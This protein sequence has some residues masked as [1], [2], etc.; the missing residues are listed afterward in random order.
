[1]LN[2]HYKIIGQK[3]LLSVLQSINIP[4][5]IILSGNSGSGRKLIAKEIAHMLGAT[6]YNCGIK[7]ED[8]RSIIEMSNMVAEKML[9]LIADAD[10]MST[11]A[12]NALL[13]IAE[14]PSEHIYIALTVS[15]SNMILPTIRSR[16]VVFTMDNYSVEELSSF[17][18]ELP[19]GT[20]LSQN[21]LTT[22]VNVCQTPGDVKKLVTYGVTAF[23]EFVNKVIDNIELA[24]LANS[25]KIADKLMLKDE[26][27]YDL[28]LFWRAFMMLCTES[29]TFDL[30]K[31]VKYADWI[32]ITSKYL[33]T[34]RIVGLNKQALFDG[35]IL[36]VRG[37]R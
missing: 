5:F 2:T 23:W 22:L 17:A 11:Q 14:E 25:F 13:K 19:Q 16:A 28:S 24:S 32:K 33:Q 31:R 35:W 1:M 4:H 18:L 7:I 15:D 21:E 29:M 37:N 20:A 27:G 3:N 9:Y 12:I 10:A 34:L 30:D 36:E 8:I 26:S 6:L